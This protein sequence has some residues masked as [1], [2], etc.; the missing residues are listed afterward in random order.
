MSHDH[1]INK[2]DMQ[3]MMDIAHLSKTSPKSNKTAN[4]IDKI[5]DKDGVTAYKINDKQ[6]MINLYGPGRKCSTR[7]CTAAAGFANMFD[8]YDGGKYTVHYPN[9]EFMSFHH[10]SEQTKD[11][12]N[13]EI[14]F[15]SDK[16]YKDY[17]KNTKEILDQTAKDENQ[18]DSL[19]EKRFG[20][21]DEKFNNA[22]HHFKHV[23]KYAPE[24]DN[25]K[26]FVGRNKL[27][28]EQF[29]EALKHGTLTKKVYQN[30]NLTDDQVSKLLD[31]HNNADW[32]EYGLHRNPAVRGHNVDRMLNEFQ[33]SPQYKYYS[34]KVGSMKNLESHHINDII[35]K[36]FHDKNYHD[37]IGDIVEN[38][39][40]FTTN[41][42]NRL[43][44]NEDHYHVIK[45]AN[46]QTIPTEH[47]KT[48]FNSSIDNGT[49]YL[50]PHA[51]DMKSIMDHNNVDDN[52]VHRVI[53]KSGIDSPRL[54][55]IMNSKNVK[56][57]HIDHIVNLYSN[58]NYIPGNI[59]SHEKITHDDLDK[60][61]FNNPKKGYDTIYSDE[62]SAY[63][64]RKDADIDKFR[65]A[66]NYNQL[67]N[68]DLDRVGYYKKKNLPE[69]HLTNSKDSK[70][71]LKNI[72]YHPE[73]THEHLGKLIDTISKDEYFTPSSDNVK[74]VLDHPNVSPQNIKDMYH[75]WGID[76]M[77]AFAFSKHPRT[78]PSVKKDIEEKYGYK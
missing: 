3:S 54:T 77:R 73:F 18:D 20:I 53:D 58:T 52:I 26:H 71:V 65:K 34:Y 16:R 5:Y 12:S 69:D 70:F 78:I 76:S 9:G 72:Q 67:S 15:S 47:L 59:I 10:Q 43:M 39:H 44:D 74:S 33:N 23:S 45:I 7:W 37:A 57:N 6:S 1:D 64:G 36:S 30:P 29:A 22:F 48:I 19:S 56:R 42:I 50:H 55:Q 49:F 32:V 46:H 25:F 21:S 24:A 40:K 75:K 66:N 63:A 68:S 35:E 14:D 51:I 28:D 2:H 11:P 27:N 4:N 13:T 60:M 17:N 61:L 38:E 31:N 8:R 62:L 41:Q